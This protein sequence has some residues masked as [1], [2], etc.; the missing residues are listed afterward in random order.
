V[1]VDQLGWIED[2]NRLDAA[3]R[4]L[5]A[6]RVAAWRADFDRMIAIEAALRQD[7]AWRRGPSSW[8]GVLGRERSELVHSRLLAWLMD[9]VAQHGLGTRVLDGVLAA[10]GLS[11]VGSADAVIRLEVGSRSSIADIV[12]DLPHGEVVIENKVD[13]LEGDRQCWRLAT[14]H[15]NAAMVFLTRAGYV[16]VTAGETL[17]RWKTLSWRDV[18]S[19][20]TTATTSTAGPARHI[21]VEYATELRRL[22]S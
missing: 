9:P 7:G 8:L 2:F 1:T 16:P 12:V 18:A 5:A 13:A 11:S 17:D 3:W 15:P 21:A 22:F 14:D 6:L 19:I 10:V 4:D 20:L